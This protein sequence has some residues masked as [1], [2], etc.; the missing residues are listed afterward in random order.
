MASF[1]HGPFRV[2]INDNTLDYEVNPIGADHTEIHDV[3]FSSKED[4]ERELALQV[5]YGKRDI[6]EMS[7]GHYA[8]HYNLEPTRLPGLLRILWRIV[9]KDREDGT[10]TAM[11]VY[12]HDHTYHLRRHLAHTVTLR[13]SA[14]SNQLGDMASDTGMVIPTQRG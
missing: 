5:E 8:D 3:L 4:A 6:D 2:A 7:G 11:L 9:D 12:P 14:L 10:D 13:I 1:L